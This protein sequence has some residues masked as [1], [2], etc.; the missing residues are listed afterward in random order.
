MN[1]NVI[2]LT[3]IVYYVFLFTCIF[4]IFAAL[5]FW[6]F[7]GHGMKFKQFLVILVIVVLSFFGAFLTNW[8]A[9]PYWK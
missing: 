4:T 1:L 2:L 6:V 8:L 3:N 7:G 5:V 9:G